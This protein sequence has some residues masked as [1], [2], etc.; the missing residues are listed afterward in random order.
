[1]LVKKC[2]IVRKDTSNGQ[3]PYAFAP[4]TRAVELWL[5][6]AARAMAVT[7]ASPQTGSQ[8]PLGRANAQ[9]LFTRS[10]MLDAWAD[11]NATPWYDG[12]ASDLKSTFL[13][14]ICRGQYRSLSATSSGRI[15][16]DSDC[17][18]IEAVARRPIRERGRQRKTGDCSPQ[19]CLD[20]SVDPNHTECAEA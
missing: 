9:Q 1:M 2:R 14:R 13:H 11:N 17:V 4:A 15:R 8:C 5:R 18:G 7:M 3:L 16:A 6:S 20:L 19:L 10:K 12:F